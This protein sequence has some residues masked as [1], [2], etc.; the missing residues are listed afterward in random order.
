MP[1]VKDITARIQ[2]LAP[3]EAALDWDNSGLQ[4][5]DPEE[6]VTRVLIAVE[7]TE[8]VVLEALE[9][10]CQLLI[11]HH[12]LI[13]QGVK[14][15]NLADPRGNLIARA[16]K[17][18]LAVFAAH[19]NLDQVRGGLNDFLA[20]KLEL[21]EVKNLQSNLKQDKLVVFVPR[22]SLKE[23]QQ[24]LFSAGAGEI[25][26]YS[27]AS[28]YT[29]GTGT[30][31]PLSGSSPAVGRQGKREEVEE[32]RLEVLYQT[33]DRRKII[34]SLKEAHPY[35][36]PA[37]DIFALEQHQNEPQ[38]ARIGKLAEPISLEK[39]LQRVKRVLN[40]AV[41]RYSGSLTGRI[42][43]IGLACGSGGDF[44]K[45]ADPGEIDL[46]LTGDVKYHELLAAREK[47]LTV[48]DAGHFA[49][50]KIFREL[51]ADYLQ[52]SFPERELEIVE[53]SRDESPW[54]LA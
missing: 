27:E 50:E 53:A 11:V 15:L 39:F 43:R 17:N 29:P 25:G 5:G 34:N 33:R 45:K 42:G 32:Y 52:G 28:F 49:T 20:E 4:L 14:S 22:D 26:N 3:A 51:I 24:A 30:F 54:Q 41:L 18:D 8:K 38:P 37:Y 44:L 40:P 19:T 16:L 6:Q 7:P 31:K 35:E 21:E 2:E 10:N 9:K 46:F 12:P 48:V 36:E 1:K 23:V 13:F 47:G